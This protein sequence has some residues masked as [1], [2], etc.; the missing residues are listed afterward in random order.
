MNVT[1]DPGGRSGI[2]PRIDLNAPQPSGADAP[3]PPRRSAPTESNALAGETLPAPEGEDQ[4]RDPA[5]AD[6]EADAP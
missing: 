5:D 2:F 1:D 3:P 4:P 6:P